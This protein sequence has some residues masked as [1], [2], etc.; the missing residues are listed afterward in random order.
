M[1]GLFYCK[2]SLLS[3]EPRTICQGI[4]TVNRY[5]HFPF[6]SLWVIMLKGKKFRGDLRV[7]PGQR[8]TDGQTVR[9]RAIGLSITKFN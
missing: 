8:Q 1:L 9:E 4:D 3:T 7:E 2:V 5:S 6:S